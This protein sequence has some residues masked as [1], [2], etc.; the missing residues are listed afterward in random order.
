M[1][2]GA[3]IQDHT[4]AVNVQTEVKRNVTIELSVLA[5]LTLAFLLVF[6]DRPIFVDVGLALLALALLILNIRYTKNVIWARFPTTLDRRSQV[7]KACIVVGP[8]TCVVAMGL[9]AT[10]LVLGYLEDGWD[11]AV[12]RVGNWRFFAALVLY[13]PWALLQQAL[14]QFYLLGR[15]RT[16]V[17]AR[18]AV[19]CTGIAYALVHLPNIGV[20]IATGIVGVF[21]A[22]IYDRY[23]VLWPLA[24]S[25]ALLG[26]AFHYWACGQDLM[27]EWTAGL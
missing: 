3:E 9:F 7:R 23:R 15:L 6:P 26:S 8:S 10:G 17:P 16:L 22:Y 18:I 5:A 1:P 25:H 21:W 13:F 2:D 12:R 19:I 27:K 24:L 4:I 14:F 20:T 11:A